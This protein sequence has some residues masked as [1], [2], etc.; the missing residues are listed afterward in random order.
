MNDA[1]IK[2]IFLANGFKEKDQGDGHMGLN[3]YVYD[4][5][6]A[7]ISAFA[8]PAEIRRPIDDSLLYGAAKAYTAALAKEADN[9]QGMVK[10][11]RNAFNKLLAIAPPNVWTSISRLVGHDE[12]TFAQWYEA[13]GKALLS[14]ELGCDDL[15]EAAWDA[16]LARHPTPRLWGRAARSAEEMVAQDTALYEAIHQLLS[17]YRLQEQQ[18]DS[19]SGYPLVDAL[20]ADGAQDISSGQREIE[21]LA[22]HL[23]GELLG[24]I[25][26]R[27]DSLESLRDVADWNREVAGSLATERDELQA[28][29]TRLHKQLKELLPVA[30]AASELLADQC[31][32]STTGNELA[33]VLAKIAR[34]S[35]NQRQTPPVPGRPSQAPKVALWVV[36]Q[37]G[38]ERCFPRYEDAL[39]RDPDV[40]PIAMITLQDHLATVVHHGQFKETI[41]HTLLINHALK[42]EHETNPE[43]ALSDLIKIEVAMAIDPAISESARTSAVPTSI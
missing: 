5:A 39:Q 3:P 38:G 41:L 6:R 12:H 10:A 25:N 9:D 4:A 8:P 43:L 36:A 22:D 31:P 30:E 13:H 17:H 20:T 1:T 21:R 28:A 2:A 40:E 29:V 26:L 32:N 33:R 24:K 42:A 7:L 16:G 27:R 18:I 19:E 14:Y 15:M 11:M 34:E 35:A 23:F 37:P